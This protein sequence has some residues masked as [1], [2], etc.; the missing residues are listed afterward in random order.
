MENG[1]FFPTQDIS[2][3]ILATDMSSHATFVSDF[4]SRLSAGLNVVGDSADARS[5]KRVLVKAC[6]VSNECRPLHVSEAWAEVL[7]QEYFA[8]VSHFVACDSFRFMCA[9]IL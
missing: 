8:Q 9:L 7:L 2:D 1:D 6:D 4:Q 3:L 5:L